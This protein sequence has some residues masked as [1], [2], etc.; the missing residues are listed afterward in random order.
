MLS[1]M[2]FPIDEVM[3][4]LFC[5]IDMML[6]CFFFTPFLLKAMDGRFILCLVKHFICALLCALVCCL[7]HVRWQTPRNQSLIP[8][9]RQQLLH[10]RSACWNNTM[11]SCSRNWLVT[12]SYLLS[13]HAF[14]QFTVL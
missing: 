2:C 3:L 11:L 5:S 10:Y 6:L 14:S 8:Q 12:A 1:I 7:I 13:Y 9:M 4:A